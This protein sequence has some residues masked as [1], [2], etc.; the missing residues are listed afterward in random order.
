MKHVVRYPIPSSSQYKG[1]VRRPLESIHSFQVLSRAQYKYPHTVGRKAGTAY[2]HSD[3]Y[4][5][6]ANENQN[7]DSTAFPLSYAP[8]I[9][10]GTGYVEVCVVI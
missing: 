4:A 8:M 1:R 7:C 3:G 5:S 6:N 10:S 2:S 9:F